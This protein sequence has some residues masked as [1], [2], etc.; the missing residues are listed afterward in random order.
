MVSQEEIRRFIS[1]NQMLAGFSGRVAR[2]TAA[3]VPDKKAITKSA[4]RFHAQIPGAVKRSPRPRITKSK[5]GG[6][7][8]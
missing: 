4:I 6:Q 1:E 5:F 7:N 2:A 3:H 8:I